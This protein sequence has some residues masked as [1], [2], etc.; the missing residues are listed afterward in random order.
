MQQKSSHAPIE[1]E[2]MYWLPPS[3]VKQSGKATTTGGIALFPYQPVEPF[4]QVLAET[5][6]IR[7]GQAAAGEADKVH[8]QG[9][10][11][12]VMPSRDVHIDDTH[13]RVAQHIA[14]EGLAL[15]R[16]AAEGAHR[17]EEL[18]HASYP[19]SADVI[20]RHHCRRFIN[21]FDHWQFT[22]EPIGK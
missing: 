14:R 16:E 12:S 20:R 8:K 17:P 21:P 11:L 3:R 19:A 15:D 4:R 6:P 7:M 10:S 1:A 13:R 22:A 2:L 18:A 9:Q 5:D